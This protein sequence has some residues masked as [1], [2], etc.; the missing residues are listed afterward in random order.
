[1]NHI[2]KGRYGRYE[3]KS[4]NKRGFIPVELIFNERKISSSMA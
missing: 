1:M 4:K 2:T 3:Q